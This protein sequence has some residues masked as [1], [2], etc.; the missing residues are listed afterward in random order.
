MTSLRHPV[1]AALTAAVTAVGTTLAIAGPAQAGTPE[2]AHQHQS[3]D[4][5]LG[6]GIQHVV[7]IMFDNVHLT[8]DEPN[9]PSDLEQMPA[10]LD[11]ITQHGVMM[12]D[13]HDVLV[14]TATNFI[15]NMTGLY[16]DRTAITQ[17]NSFNYYDSAGNTHPGVSFAY[18]TDPIYDYTGANADTNYNLQYTADRANV[19]NDTNINTPAPWVPY[20]RAGCNVG[21]VGMANTVLE[22][23]A[24]DIPTVFGSGSPEEQEAA[25]DSSKAA[26]D[27]TGYAVHCAATSA[28]CASGQTDSLP[29][30]PGGYQGF[31]AL[32]GNAEVQPAISPSGP[33]HAL[34]GSVIADEDGNVGFPGFDSLTPT[35]SLAYG[36][37]MLE[38]GVQ[39]ANIYVSD[40][41]GDH[42]G[43]NQGDLGPGS[44]PY[45]QQL[46]D[47]NSAFAQF[48]TRLAHDGITPANTLFVVTTDEGDHFSGS[49]PTPAGCTGATG[50]YCSYAVRSEVTVK[51]TGLLADATG[52]TTPFAIHSDPAP[53]LW[54]TGQPD[55]TDPAVRQLSRDIAGLQIT[56]PLTGATE[57]VAYQ[58][59]DPV[60][61]KILHFVSSDPART[62]TLTLF[63]GEDSYV[64]GGGACAGASCVAVNTSTSGSHF[65][66]NHGGIWP[67]MQDIWAGYVGPGISARGTN[68]SVWTD[69]VDARPTVLALTG[70]H[71]D[72]LGDGRV[73]VEICSPPA[74][75]VALRAHRGTV[76][77]LGAVYK[78]ILGADGRFA[79]DTLAASTT[80]LSSGSAG[81]DA[82]Y[83]R[84]ENQ[85]IALDAWRNRLADRISTQ[86]NG[87]AFAGHRIDER[88]AKGLIAQAKS[89][90]GAAHLLA[91]S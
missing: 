63:S 50:N 18:W 29:D 80:A 86:L 60:E 16:P 3:A 48:F 39:V 41:H 83:T 13:A 61:E 78:Q 77:R 70:L 72:Y 22:N 23:T 64:T 15:S 52:N 84:I 33:V 65:A 10:L 38:H 43:A 12:A 4:C 76:L 45:E 75:P 67:D 1:A 40:V 55:R 26:A 7:Q 6:N 27:F 21:E 34:D 53:A 66:W 31:K 30:E 73:L 35:N 87:A 9:V 57:P 44:Q 59:A 46:A 69:Q 17:S 25:T 74:L 32:F 81:D 47:Y 88:T 19:P 5:A 51:L 37:Q 36:A 82:T 56:N 79:E 14:H 2:P 42:T 89:L 20:T 11:F 8:R 91:S 54:V 28:L 90:L 71:D 24:T 62:P 85:L 68:T 58:M 49:E